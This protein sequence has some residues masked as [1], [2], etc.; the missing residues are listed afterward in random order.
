MTSNSLTKT[1][2]GTRSQPRIGLALAG[3]G[4][5]GAVY[6]IGALCALE[7]ALEGLSLTGLTYY[8]GVSAGGFI[9]AGLANRMSPHELCA[10]FIDGND[11]TSAV[12]APAWLMAPAYGEFLRRS[13]ALPGV[14]AAALWRATVGGKSWLTA[15]EALGLA[16]PT[17]VFSS[18]QIDVQLARLFSPRDEPMNFSCARA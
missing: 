18:A 9:A 17:G 12:C 16:L 15:L 11:P 2:L 3:G 5:L 8:I 1:R 7:E 14:A 6:E 4:P 10:A 13:I